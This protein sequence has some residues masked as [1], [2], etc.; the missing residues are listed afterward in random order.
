MLM[1]VIKLAGTDKL[2]RVKLHVQQNVTKS[3]ERRRAAELG[4]NR[5]SC[6]MITDF[7]YD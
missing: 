2:K 4:G 1:R 6:W 3:Q 5:D 7:I